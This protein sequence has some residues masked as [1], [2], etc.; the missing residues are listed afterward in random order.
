MA[1][2]NPDVWRPN[3]P[4]QHPYLVSHALEARQLFISSRTIIRRAQLSLFPA[5]IHT[6]AQGLAELYLQRVSSYST[7]QG[8]VTVSSRMEKWSHPLA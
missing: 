5:M 2:K 6:I 8:H 4:A 7:I 3:R 1:L